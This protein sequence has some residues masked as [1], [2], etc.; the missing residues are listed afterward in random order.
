MGKWTAK[1]EGKILCALFDAC[2]ADARHT[3]A[4]DIDPVKELKVGCIFCEY[5]SIGFS[6]ERE[7]LTL[8]IDPVR[9]TGQSNQSFENNNNT[10]TTQQHE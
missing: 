2:I 6:R 8:P 7:R 1:K 4:D 9:V 10:T 5:R 3:K